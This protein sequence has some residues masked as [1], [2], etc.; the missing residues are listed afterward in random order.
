MAKVMLIDPPPVKGNRMGRI[1]GSIGSNKAGQAWPPYD[2]QVLAGYCRLQGHEYRILDANN[3]ELSCEETGRQ[4]AAYAPDWVVYMTTFP[5][6]E[7]DAL[8]AAAAKKAGSGILTACISLSIGSLRDPELRLKQA[9]GLD[10][11]VWGEPELPL[12]KLFDGEKPESVKGLYYKSKDGIKFTGE[13]DKPENLDMLGVPEHSGLPINIYKCPVSM[14][15]PMTIVNCSRGCSNTCVHCLSIFQKPLRYRSVENVVKELEHI[16]S[17]GIREIKFYDCSLPTN[18]EFT[19]ELCREMTGRKYGFS[20]NCNAR[21]ETLDEELLKA[22]KKSGCHTV[23]VGCESSDAGILKNMNKNETPEQIER[24][25][26]LIKASGMRV[27]VYLTFGLEGET[28]QTMKD[29]YRFVKKL[30]PEFVTFGIV[31]PTPG[32]RLYGS[33]SRQGYLTD[34]ERIFKDPNALP[35]FSYPGLSD[36]EILSFTRKAYLNYYFSVGYILRTLAAVRSP[37]GFKNLA[38]TALSLVWRY[39]FGK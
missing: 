24:A 4:I 6:F 32:T 39:I 9:S 17:L 7:D 28:K 14:R 25:V 36:R 27:L 22:M 37:R 16:K 18:R 30:R 26:R 12:M 38:G 8:V 3:L 35:S 20:W 1:L 29:T 34:N 10:Y 11:L 15:H 33:L 19:L 2:L 23:A 21:A 31:V 5:T 13:S